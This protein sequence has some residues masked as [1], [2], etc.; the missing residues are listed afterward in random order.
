MDILR[1][2]SLVS[3]T[4]IRGSPSHAQ[5][6]IFSAGV[7]LFGAAWL[8][9]NVGIMTNLTPYLTALGGWNI[10]GICLLGVLA[11]RLVLT[12]YWIWKEDLDKI[13][14]L[15]NDNILLRDKISSRDY[16]TPN[17]KH[18]ALKIISG[19]NGPFER[20]KRIRNS[21]IP[22]EM[23]RRTVR[24][25]VNNSGN[26]YLSN[27]SFSIGSMWPADW[28]GTDIVWIDLENGFD[29]LP[30][31]TRYIDIATLDENNPQDNFYGKNVVI[32]KEPG[33][34]FNGHIMIPLSDQTKKT[35]KHS[36][37]FRATSTEAVANE[38]KAYIRV[39]F[40][41]DCAKLHIDLV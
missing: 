18:D 23:V 7:L 10:A 16:P 25:G 40:S 17:T 21:I 29:L 22:Y 32:A 1:Y 6:A 13:T 34:W 15:T 24:I 20:I 11:I 27:C 8:A 31:Q 26:G 41:P 5:D 12:P 38:C 30:G 14:S 3:R 4:A 19:E 2:I 36:I 35:M 37:S 9:P 28:Q 39:D 33:T